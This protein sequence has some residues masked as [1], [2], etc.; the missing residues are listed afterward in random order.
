L[1]KDAIL[2]C[3]NRKEVDN[4]EN[5]KQTFFEFRRN[6]VPEKIQN[7]PYIKEK[8]LLQEDRKSEEKPLSDYWCR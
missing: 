5:D 2:D 1:C 8:I 4:K 7:L 6:C 3:Q